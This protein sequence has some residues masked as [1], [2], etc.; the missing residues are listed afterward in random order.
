MSAE[1]N[2]SC[3]ITGHKLIEKQTE[4]VELLRKKMSLHMETIQ[5]I[6]AKIAK[7][8]I[9]LAKL[10]Q[11]DQAGWWSTLTEQEQNQVAKAM[12]V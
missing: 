10:K 2:I 5:K 12:N 6:Q 11:S 3:K 7:E 8:E 9:Y 4:F 1:N